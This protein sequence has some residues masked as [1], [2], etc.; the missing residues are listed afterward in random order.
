MNR[1]AIC[2]KDKDILTNIGGIVRGLCSDSCCES[3]LYC[4]HQ[5]SNQIQFQTSPGRHVIEISS[6]KLYLFY[7][8]DQEIIYNIDYV[9]NFKDI[10]E[11]INKIQVFK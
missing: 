11:K 10:I 7:K 4:I 8:S 5:F 2:L 9:V 3:Q 6:K 1:C